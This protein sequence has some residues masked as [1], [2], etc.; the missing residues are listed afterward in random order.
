MLKLK[1]LLINLNIMPTEEF[2]KILE[3]LELEE[4]SE[5]HLI[6][7]YKTLLD[8]GI[9]NCLE[10]DQQDIFRQSMETLY[11]DSNIH[12]KIIHNIRVKYSNL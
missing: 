9:E 8:L 10:G 3:E 1:H 11:E 5:N 2:K 7:L 12:K 4:E 6:W